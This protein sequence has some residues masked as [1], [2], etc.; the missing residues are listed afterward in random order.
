MNKIKKKTMKI[1]DARLYLLI[2]LMVLC[3]SCKDKSTDSSQPSGLLDDAFSLAAQNPNLK[4]LIVYKDDHIVKERYFHT[5]DSL[6]PH[7]VRSVTKSVMA[8]LI[9]IAIDKGVIPSEVQSIGG[10]LQPLVG[11]MDSMKANIKISDVLSMSAGFSGNELANPSE[12]NSWFNASDQVAYTLSK[13]M[14][15]TPG[16]VFNYDSGVAH[17][18]SAILTQ[19]SGISTL[20]FGESNLFRQLGIA[21][22]FWEIDKRGINNGGAGLRL[23]PYDMLKIGQLYLNKG[24]YNGSRIISEEWINKV[25][26]FKITTNNAQPF[27]PSYGYCWWIG[28]IHSHDYFFANGYGGQFI[29][30]VPDIRLIVIATNIWSGVSTS[31]ANTQWYSTLDLIMNK[32]LVLY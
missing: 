22:P 4:C 25:S 10:Y 7:D 19:A 16:R 14:V 18:L 13:P 29:V 27:G 1:G 9:G 11:P 8:T 21:D 6:S 12:Y 20:Q 26:S 5:G 2:F 30:V 3:T 28:N 24:M 15:S 31:T 17:L 32:I 23:T